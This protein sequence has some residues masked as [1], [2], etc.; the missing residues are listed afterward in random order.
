MHDVRHIIFGK[1]LMILFWSVLDPG[2]KEEELNF[3]AGDLRGYVATGL[4]LLYQI[5][6]VILLLNLLIALMNSTVITE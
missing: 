2:N 3:S 4:L 5:L 6:V 1:T